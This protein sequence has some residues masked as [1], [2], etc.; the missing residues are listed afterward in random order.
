MV[1]V[2]AVLCC[3]AEG[4]GGGSTTKVVVA[5]G[6]SG[7]CEL[8]TGAWPLVGGDCA[9]CSTHLI[10]EVLTLG[11]VGMGMARTNCWLSGLFQSE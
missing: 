3:T 8:A 10:L 5:G 11:V 2:L 4:G 9:C 1:N 6:T 7:Y